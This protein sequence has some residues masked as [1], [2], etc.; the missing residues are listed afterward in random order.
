LAFPW[1]FPGGIGDIKE[2]REYDIDI[3][4]WAQNLLFS[5][6]GQF[7][8]DNLWCFFVLNYI[9]RHRNTSQSQWFVSDFVGD[10][11]P[12]L[13]AL[14]NGDQSFIDKLMYFWKSCSRI[15]RILEIKK[16]R[17]IFMD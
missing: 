3:A 1:L 6:D 5:E 8:K 17:I 7:A 12:T 2:S 16:S 9:Q 13:E 14:Q 10:P 4:D 11:P 15:K